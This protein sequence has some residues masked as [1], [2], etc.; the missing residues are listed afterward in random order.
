MAREQSGCSGLRLFLLVLE[1]EKKMS[2]V[3][4]GCLE[5]KMGDD[6]F[7]VAVFF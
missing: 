4:G 5:K 2:R 3:G 6:R 7:R 1:E